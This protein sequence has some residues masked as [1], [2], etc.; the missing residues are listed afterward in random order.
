MKVRRSGSRADL[1]VRAGSPDPAVREHAAAG[2]G[3]PARTRRSAPL[4]E[5][6]HG[7]LSRVRPIVNR[8]SESQFSA[9]QRR[10]VRDGQPLLWPAWERPKGRRHKTTVCPT[11]SKLQPSFR[12]D[13]SDIFSTFY[14]EERSVT[15]ARDSPSRARSNPRTPAAAV[16]ETPRRRSWPRYRWRAPA[17]GSRPDTEDGGFGPPGAVRNCTRHHPRR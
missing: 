7:R 9:A 13:P 16:L 10:S 15:P 5:W 14:R 6:T 8:P 2:R 4:P 1:P 12:D 17:R 11:G 3:R